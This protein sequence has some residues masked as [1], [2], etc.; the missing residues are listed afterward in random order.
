MSTSAPPA[1]SPLDSFRL[2]DQIAIVTGASSGLGAHFAEVLHAVGAQVVLTARRG[3]RL[4][5]LATELPGAHVCAADRADEAERERLGAA[6]V[7][8]FGRVDVH[9][10]TA[11]VGGSAAV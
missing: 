7:E 10:T 3:E 9:F 1:S 8:R 5:A 6:G 11:G 2:D 4:D